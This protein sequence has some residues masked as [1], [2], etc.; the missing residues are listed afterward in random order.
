MVKLPKPPAAQ[1]A[2]PWKQIAINCVG[3]YPPGV[4]EPTAEIGPSVDGLRQK[5]WNPASAGLVPNLF[6]SAGTVTRVGFDSSDWY[7][8]PVSRDMPTPD[9]QMM[10]TWNA[11]TW[12]VVSG[13]NPGES[14]DVVVYV[15]LPVEKSSKTLVLLATASEGYRPDGRSLREFERLKKEAND[16]RQIELKEPPADSHNF[17]GEYIRASRENN[18]TG[19]YLVFDG[20]KAGLDGCIYITTYT[21]RAWRD[22]A[23]RHKQYL[24]GLQIRRNIGQ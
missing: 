7:M 23:I 15:D 10:Y 12:N 1:A 5:Y 13:L 21:P 22:E 11:H 16:F 18:Y 24:S 3:R 2:K 6:D 17:Q 20:V 8:S 19:N 14:F 4:N 9:H